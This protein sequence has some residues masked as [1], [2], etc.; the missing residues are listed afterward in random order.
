MGR[1]AGNLALTSKALH[2]MRRC[3]D[4]VLYRV[5]M[6][7]TRTNRTAADLFLSLDQHGRGYTCG[8]TQRFHAV[9]PIQHLVP[10]RTQLG[11]QNSTAA[12]GTCFT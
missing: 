12:S 4:E 8:F 1:G 10:V 3:S 9:E 2:T 7:K 11:Y 5:G 6:Y